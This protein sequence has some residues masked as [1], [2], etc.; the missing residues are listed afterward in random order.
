MSIE[1]EQL[2]ERFKFGQRERSSF[3]DIA[4]MDESSNLHGCERESKVSGDDY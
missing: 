3:E 4:R 2:E 1:I